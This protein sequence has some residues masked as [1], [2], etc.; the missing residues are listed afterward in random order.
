MQRHLVCGP[1][2]LY[3]CS[4]AL[5]APTF[6]DLEAFIMTLLVPVT[7]MLA[8]SVFAMLPDRCFVAGKRLHDATTVLVPGTHETN[9]ASCPA[10]HPTMLSCGTAALDVND[11]VWGAYV[12]SLEEEQ[13]VSGPRGHAVGSKLTTTCRAN[14]RLSFDPPVAVCSQ[15][16]ATPP[17]Y[18]TNSEPWPKQS[19]AR[20]PNG[21]LPVGCGIGSAVGSFA[22]VPSELDGTCTC[23]VG[24][25]LVPS[26]NP[27]TNNCSAVCM[28]T[29]DVTDYVIVKATGTEN[30]TLVD[31][32]C[33]NSTVVL[34][35]GVDSISL[36]RQPFAGW[37]PV[38]GNACRCQSVL[39]GQV[40]T[41][42]AVCGQPQAGSSSKPL[43][44]GVII[45]SSVGG[46]IVFL[47]IV[48]ALF[49]FLRKRR[50][51]YQAVN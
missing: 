16:T 27:T 43:R 41:C 50:R 44:H 3:A 29:D 17:I 21:T 35:C 42:Y 38:P 6:P 10:G 7:V 12:D 33:P 19:V 22:A 37:A 5:V 31:V 51:G 24:Q 36:K 2:L 40:G 20:C 26:D 13:V 18:V 1:G 49:L 11:Q 47:L 23:D 8:V 25:D 48:V 15:E 32:T 39:A 34:G 9:K 45:G 46:A 30:S 4:G 28:S 14:V